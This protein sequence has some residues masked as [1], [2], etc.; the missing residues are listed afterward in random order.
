MRPPFSP[1]QS[2]MGYFLVVLSAF[3]FATKS[4]LA[5]MSYNYGVDAITVLTIRM[6]FAGL[7]FAGILAY[8]LSFRQWKLDF[9]AGQWGAIVAL[10][11]FGYYL[12]ALFDFSGLM[13][14]D[15]SLGRM[16]LF[17][18]PT[19]VVLINAAISRSHI[20]GS[21][22]L[23]LGL[24]YGG[25]FMM[26][27]PNIGGGQ[28]NLWLGSGLIFTSA[29]L[30][31]SYMVS[32]DRLL[33]NLDAIRLT[34]LIMVVS[35]ISVIIH[36]SVTNDFK[37]LLSVAAPVYING[38]LMGLFSTVLPIYALAAGVARVGASRAALISMMGPVLTLLMGVLLLDEHLT[39][40]QLAGMF[41]VMAGVSRVGK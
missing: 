12:S 32:I 41:L 24:C 35:S 37:S 38:A 10:G 21:T 14:V 16:I 22:W 3:T 13:Y 2:H 11:I 23:A 34:S 26:M 25:I 8:K 15:A 39:I 9:T 18:Y 5:K 4:I 31:A 7:I 19:L 36:F 27:L 40:I 29:L 6:I 1:S 17:L 28:S 33:R 30:Y 20:S